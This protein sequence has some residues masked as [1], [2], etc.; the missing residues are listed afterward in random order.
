MGPEA[1]R[2]TLE[3]HASELRWSGVPEVNGVDD[4]ILIHY[5]VLSAYYL[6][7]R[8]RG[9]D[10]A[11]DDLPERIRLRITRGRTGPGS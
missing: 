7:T 10:T 5:S 3:T 11:A 2:V 4:L 1:L 6:P 9:P 8:A